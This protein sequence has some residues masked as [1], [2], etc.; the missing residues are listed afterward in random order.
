MKARTKKI[1]IVLSFV[2]SIFL[3]ALYWE[4]ISLFIRGLRSDNLIRGLHPDMKPKVRKLVKALK[5]RG[6][7]IVILSGYRSPEKQAELYE[8]Y[9]SGQS[10]LPASS[11]YMSLHN[12]GLAVDI[13]EVIDGVTVHSTANQNWDIISQEAGKLGLSWGG[14]FNDKPHFYFDT[15]IPTASMKVLVQDKSMVDIQGWL[16]LNKVA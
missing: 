1:L 3:I 2:S 4:S 13:A 7:D 11:P 8:A 9:K 15:G 16:K 6:I 5:A 12:Y 14:S 10:A